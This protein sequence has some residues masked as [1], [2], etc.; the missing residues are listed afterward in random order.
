MANTPHCHSENAPR[1]HRVS[2]LHVHDPHTIFSALDLQEGELFLDLGCGTGDFSR[3]AAERVGTTGKVFA[4][5]R[6]PDVVAEINGR[7]AREHMTNLHALVADLADPLPFQDETANLCF[8]CTVLH[9]IGSNAVRQFLFGEMYRVLRPRGR[10]AV[11]ECKKE[12]SSFGPPPEIRIAEEELD[13]MASGVGFRK[14]TSTDLG[15][16]VLVL[17]EKP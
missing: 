6:W 8:L 3:I 13:A 17:Y 11:V 2:S 4:L 14:R 10:A 1:R 9:S 5:D 16:T 12:P 7:A 15:H